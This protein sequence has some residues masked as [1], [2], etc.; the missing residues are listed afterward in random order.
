MAA[1]GTDLIRPDQARA[2]LLELFNGVH[3]KMVA[4]NNETQTL[5]AQ[6]RGDVQQ[7][8]VTNKAAA[9]EQVE[10]LRG[11]TREAIV[12]VDKKISVIDEP[13]CFMRPPG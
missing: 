8:L 5:I 10:A 11:H 9:V 12:E 6:L 4:Q 1:Q 2:T 7:A 3:Q 13:F